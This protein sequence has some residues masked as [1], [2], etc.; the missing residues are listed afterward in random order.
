MK[1]HSGLPSVLPYTLTGKEEFVIV[2]SCEAVDKILADS[3]K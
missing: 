2:D 3:I 1:T